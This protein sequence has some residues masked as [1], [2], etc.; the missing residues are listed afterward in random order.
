MIF[1]QSFGGVIKQVK[2]SL[3]WQTW[4]NIGKHKVRGRIMRFRDIESFNTTLA[5]I[6]TRRENIPTS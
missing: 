3:H 1:C 5:T 2:G 6:K 4:E